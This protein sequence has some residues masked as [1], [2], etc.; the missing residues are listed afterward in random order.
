MSHN[1]FAFPWEQVVKDLNS[2]VEK[3]L[4]PQEVKNRLARYGDNCLP[5]HVKKSN[6]KILLGQLD[7]PILYL[8]GLAAGLDFIFFGWLEGLTVCIVILITILIGFFMELSAVRSMETLRNIGQL[9]CSVL[10]AAKVQNVPSTKIVPGDIILFAPGDVIPADARLVE[11]RNLEMKEAILTGESAAVEKDI[12]PLGPNTPMTGQKNMVFKGTAVNKGFGR[13]VVVGT[14]P[15]TVLGEIQQ[16]GETA[17]ESKP[18]LDKKL[19]QL[20]RRLIWLMLAFVIPMILYGVLTGKD[21]LILLQTGI[22]LA[23]ATIPEGLPVVVTI[24]LARGML[25][26]SKQQVII[27]KMEAVE[28]LG[29]VTM[30][31]TDKTGT[32]TEDAMTVHTLGFDGETFTDLDK[33]DYLSLQNTRN[34]FTYEQ[35]G[36]C[37][38]LCNDIIPGEDVPYRDSIDSSLFRFVENLGLDPEQIRKRFPE[39]FKL[40]FDEERKL[41]AT[42]NKKEDG[43]HAIFVK[44]AF[45]NVAALCTGR[46]FGD[47][48]VPFNNREQWN[49]TVDEMSSQGLRTIAMAY[50]HVKGPNLEKDELLG[51]LVLI[52]IVGFIDPAREDVK[53]IVD[54]Y[55]KAGVQIVMMTGDHPKTAEKIAL[56]IGLLENG[57]SK[58]LEGKDLDLSNIQD[59]KDQNILLGTKV[60]ARVTPKQKLELISFFQERGHVVVMFGDGINDVPA[61]IKSDI[62]IAMGKRGT[63]AAREAADVILRDDRFGSVELAIRQGRMLY[64]HIRQFLVYLLS[65]NVAEIMTVGIAALLI[66]PSPLLPL[67]ILFLNL[68][69]DVFPALAL[70]FGKGEEGVMDRPPRKTDE[71]ILTSIHWRSTFLYG[72]SITFSVLGITLFGNYSL[73]LSSLQINNMAFYTLIVAQLLNVFNMPKEKTSFLFNEVTKNPW[74]W[75][76]IVLSIAITALAY[77]IPSTSNALSLV[78]LQGKEFLW[79]ILFG[80]GSLLLSQILKKMGF[81]Q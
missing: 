49:R 33:G 22:A 11:E 10:R 25:R 21:L 28:I 20:S 50:K 18:A 77:L 58:V 40:P 38:V 62:G 35:F 26:L 23:V 24:A 6:F 72:A 41:M 27:K 59:G 45:E 79:P 32:L 69:T 66:L 55:K 71:P 36:L 53:D 34:K 31:A 61:L 60:F 54:I 68:V 12:L 65:C 15:E 37:C 39:T 5:V 75:G 29:S 19:N 63:G 67:Q 2:N 9:E 16:L 43:S 78:P 3:G 30:V 73:N 51:D 74:V 1:A 46:L 42:A 17:E 76:A 47:K 44:G 14:G 48:A 8:L 81:A 70:G 57:E 64:E 80:F 52:G 4:P 13:A 7:N 56:D